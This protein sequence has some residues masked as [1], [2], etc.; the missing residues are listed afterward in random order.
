MP[1]VIYLC[2]SKFLKI[3]GDGWRRYVKK[4]LLVCSLYLFFQKHSVFTEATPVRSES[5][6]EA[7]FMNLCVLGLTDQDSAL[8][9][10]T[11]HSYA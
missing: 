5:S 11:K 7:E 8:M 6:R 1:C 4:K 3:P 10:Q 2:K 9:Q